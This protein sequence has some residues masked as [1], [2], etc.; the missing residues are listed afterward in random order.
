MVPGPKSNIINRVGESMQEDADEEF[1]KNEGKTVLK[2]MLSV[3]DCSEPYLVFLWLCFGLTLQG[4]SLAH[5]HMLRA[6]QLLG[7]ISSSSLSNLLSPLR[8]FLSFVSA[9]V[10]PFVADVLSFAAENISLPS[11]PFSLSKLGL[12]ANGRSVQF[13]LAAGLHSTQL[14]FSSS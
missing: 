2:Q 10:Y 8:G 11:W 4:L 6:H 3:Q 1:K 9:C 13:L 7:L 5:H 12:R 14:T